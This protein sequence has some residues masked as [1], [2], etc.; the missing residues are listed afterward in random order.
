[1]PKRRP[2]LVLLSLV[3]AGCA[4]LA[5]S[6]P[7]RVQFAGLEPLPGESLEWRMLLKLR[8]QN[9]NEQPV[10]FDGA[11]VE[12][13]LR[14]Q[15]FASGVSDARGSVPRFGETVIAIPVTVS[16]LS[17]ARQALDFVAGRQG[18]PLDYVLRGKLAGPAL[19]GVR[20]QSTGELTWPPAG[21]P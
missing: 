17:V 10:D 12:L 13:D 18:A 16:A 8:V 9:P 14:G 2:I 15:P 20:F 5:G 4:G 11:S 3:L 1:M 6:D 19:G 7:V 21:L